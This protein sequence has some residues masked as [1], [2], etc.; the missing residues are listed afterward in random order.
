MDINEIN[1]NSWNRQAARYQADADLLFDEV[2]Y[3]SRHWFTEK[4]LQ[5]IGNVQGK[6][7]L[8]L[9]CGGANCG[10]SLAKQGA[11]VTCVDFSEQQLSFAKTNAKRENV[12][13]KFIASPMQQVVFENEF[14]IIISMAALSYVEDIHGIFKNAGKSLKPGGSFVFSLTDPTFAAIA[15]YYLWDVPEVEKSYFYSGPEKWKWDKGDDFD[16]ISY[17]RP[18]YEYINALSEHGLLVEKFYQLKRLRGG[19]SRD[20]KLESIFP[21]MM[22]FKAV[23]K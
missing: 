14:D 6:K 3:G 18:I 23:K 16:F 19:E 8:E 2:D 22:V 15:C 10:I 5:L 4:D 12:N 1:K 13:I 20:E 9:G 11:V 21:R 17:R 7:V